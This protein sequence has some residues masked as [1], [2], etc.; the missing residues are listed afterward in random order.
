MRVGN[1][2]IITFFTFFITPFLPKAQK[3]AIVERGEK[4]VF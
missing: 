2:K 1:T 4:N 3:G